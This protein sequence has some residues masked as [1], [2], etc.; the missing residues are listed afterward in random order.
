M[1][2]VLAALL[3]FSIIIANELSAQGFDRDKGQSGVHVFKGN[4]VERATPGA[5]PAPPPSAL[6]ALDLKKLAGAE[7]GSVFVKLTPKEPSVLNRGALVFVS[8]TLVEGGENYARWGQPGG[9]PV[10][11]G[12]DDEQK[13]KLDMA[14][15]KMDA[16]YEGRGGN[17]PGPRAAPNSSVEGSLMLWLRSAANRKYF[18]DCVVGGPSFNVNGPGG[19][20]T[21]QLKGV[22]AHLTFALDA[23][24]AGWYPFQISGGEFG[25][26]FYS[27]EVTNL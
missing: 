19:S 22:T 24:T 9:K 5:R 23:S 26:T 7:P 12:P 8:P 13:Q 18:I 11:T 20:Q 21:F 14:K 1:F 25:W 3:A 4:A 17:R 6:N 16:A 2:V 15:A 27:C 10:L